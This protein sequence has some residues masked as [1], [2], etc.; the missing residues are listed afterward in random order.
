MDNQGRAEVV[1]VLLA[2]LGGRDCPGRIG[3]AELEMS[4]TPGPHP[5]GIGEY[6]YSDLHLVRGGT[7]ENHDGVGFDVS[8]WCQLDGL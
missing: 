2:I 3:G 7:L 1:V 4:V 8:E 6:L 5:K